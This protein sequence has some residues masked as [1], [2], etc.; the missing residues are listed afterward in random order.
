MNVAEKPEVFDRTVH[1]TRHNAPFSCYSP[2][3]QARDAH[4][5]DQKILEGK[6]NAVFLCTPQ[7]CLLTVES[8][9]RGFIF[10]PSS[11]FFLP[12]LFCGRVAENLLLYKCATLLLFSV[13]VS[14]CDKLSLSLFSILSLLSFVLSLSLSLSDD[15]LVVYSV[16]VTGFLVS[17]QHLTWHP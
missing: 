2:V 13:Y 16:S 5:S 17:T 3:L 6:A 15:G 14:C 7:H 11:S 8:S 4:N 9:W 10:I 1:L 12:S